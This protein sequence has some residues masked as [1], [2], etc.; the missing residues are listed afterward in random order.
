MSPDLPRV[1]AVIFDLDGTLVD[2]IDDIADSLDH[3]LA[4]AG[5]AIPSRADYHRFIGTGLRDLVKRAAPDVSPR[6]TEALIDAFRA[7][8]GDHLM[9]RSKLYD[10][11][12]EV[13]D[14]LVAAAIPIGVLSN[15]PDAMT[16][17]ICAAMLAPWPIGAIAG[18]RAD[19]PRKPNPNGAF[20]IAHLLGVEAGRCAFVGDTKTDM[21][22]ATAARM[23]PVGVTW[24]FRDRAELAAHGAAHVVDVAWALLSILLEPDD[25]G[26]DPAA[27]RPWR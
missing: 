24:G 23:L 11:I 2:T 27:D 5:L 26:A 18:E 17:R 15:K 22:T 21:L 9:V 1:G 20:R 19:I 14:E 12:N 8:Y 4:E 3:V 7:Y 13:L 10:G 6:E 16:Q 25:S